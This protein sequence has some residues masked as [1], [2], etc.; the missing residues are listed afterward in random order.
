MHMHTFTDKNNSRSPFVISS[1]MY[2]GS[3]VSRSLPACMSS[4]LSGSCR[5]GEVT[6]EVRPENV[7]LGRGVDVPAAEVWSTGTGLDV[8]AIDMSG[9]VA[10]SLEGAREARLASEL[11]GRLSV[12][13]SVSE[14][15]CSMKSK[16]GFAQS[17][18]S[19]ARV[20]KTS[21]RSTSSNEE[22]C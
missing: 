16:V 2:S 4:F 12:S 13:W 18:A 14:S 20:R 15:V 17:A 7:S 6:A 19:S 22:P 3:S 9:R 8:D 5:G 1:A 11:R 10:E 21:R